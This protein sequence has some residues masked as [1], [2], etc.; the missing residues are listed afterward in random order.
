ML[1]LS[2]GGL[3]Q[4]KNEVD[5]ALGWWWKTAASVQAI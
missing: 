2:D 1:S 4:R 5:W 3:N